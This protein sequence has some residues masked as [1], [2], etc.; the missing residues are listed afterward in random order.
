MVFKGL[1]EEKGKEE[2][3]WYLRVASDTEGLLFFE[4][5]DDEGDII[6][7]LF[8]MDI[9]T[10]SISRRDEVPERFGFDLGDR[11]RIMIRT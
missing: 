5:M 3:G 1:Y 10:G 9:Q 7:T 4:A 11:G 6:A 8:A 2:A